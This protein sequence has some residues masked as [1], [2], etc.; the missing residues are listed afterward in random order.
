MVGTGLHAIGQ[1]QPGPVEHG[2]G[3]LVAAYALMGLAA[4]LLLIAAFRRDRGDSGTHI[5]LHVEAGRDI[6]GPVYVG[7]THLGD[8]VGGRLPADERQTRR[9]ALSTLVSE[10]APVRAALE[11]ALEAASPPHAD[12][13]AQEAYTEWEAR[14]LAVVG[15][16]LG[17]DHAAIFRQAPSALTRSRY[18]AEMQPLNVEKALHRIIQQTDWLIEQ[19]RLL[20]D[21]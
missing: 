9:E 21:D 4:L 12:R 8:N 17:T 6:H 16:V 1:A 10:A 15:D 20:R 3:I 19:W 11:S 18:G 2:D 7:D 14:A 5:G 13:Q